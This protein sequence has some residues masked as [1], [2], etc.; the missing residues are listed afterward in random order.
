MFSVTSRY[1]GIP[2]T[3][4]TRPDG[5]TIAYVRRRL[6]PPLD[7]F[8]LLLE[9]AVKEGERL[10]HIANTYLG[11]PEQFWRIADANTEPQP[12]DLVQT[13]GRRLRITLPEGISGAKSLG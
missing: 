9:H 8:E 11:D 3:T 2:T 1:Y 13:P 6:L 5:T 12:D 4:M 7:R 10:D